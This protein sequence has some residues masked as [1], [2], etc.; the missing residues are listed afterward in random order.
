[1]LPTGRRI[2]R[3]RFKKLQ[4]IGRGY[5]EQSKAVGQNY[6]R[7]LS[8]PQSCPAEVIDWPAVTGQDAAGVVEPVIGAGEVF[9]VSRDPMGL[10]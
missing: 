9:Q 10:T 5:T 1:M 4:P 6:S 7:C 3:G 2:P 8:K